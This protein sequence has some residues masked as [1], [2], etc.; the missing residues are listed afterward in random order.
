MMVMQCI[1]ANVAQIMTWGF[2]DNSLGKIQLKNA[3]IVFF[4]ST[5]FTLF[6]TPPQP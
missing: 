4:F 5:I 6:S 2:S 1:A 3:T